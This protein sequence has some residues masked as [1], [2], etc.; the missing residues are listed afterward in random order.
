[1]KMREYRLAEY[2]AFILGVALALAS[3]ETQAQEPS[4]RIDVGLALRYMPTG[5][6]E[7]SGRSGATESDLGAYPAFIGRILIAQ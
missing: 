3:S 6:F 5:W 4:R 7:W 2:R 1:V